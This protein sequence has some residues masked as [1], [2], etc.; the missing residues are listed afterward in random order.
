MGSSERTED[1]L[2]EQSLTGCVLLP[3]PAEAGQF[4]AHRAQG[5]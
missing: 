2:A 4:S 1:K 3:A 5:Q